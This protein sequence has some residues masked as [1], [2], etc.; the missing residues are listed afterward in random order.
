MSKKKSTRHI[1]LKNGRNYLSVF[2]SCP[3]MKEGRCNGTFQ[4]YYER[5]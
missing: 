1:N 4:A 5:K 3:G 2:N